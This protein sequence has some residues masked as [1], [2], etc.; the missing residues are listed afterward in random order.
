MDY[1]HIVTIVVPGEQ[2]DAN[3]NHRPD[4]VNPASTVASPG[5]MQPQTGS[6]VTTG[7]NTQIGDWVVFLPAGTAI[8]G[9][10]RVLWKGRTFEVIGP[11]AV[12]DTGSSLDHVQAQLREITGA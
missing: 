6:E 1:P 10:R 3:N 8:D 4:W 7:R 2:I 12:W 11:P 9:T 5:F